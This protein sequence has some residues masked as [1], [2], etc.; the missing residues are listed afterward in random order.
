MRWNPL[1]HLRRKDD[2]ASPIEVET[3]GLAALRDQGLV[4]PSNQDQALATETPDGWL[5][6]AVADGVGGAAGGEV[7]SSAAMD[8]LKGATGQGSVSDPRLWLTSAFAAANGRVREMAAIDADRPHMA[9]TLVAALVDEEGRAW[10]ANVGDSRAYGLF[11][12]ALR[13]LTEDDSWV[14]ERVRSGELGEAEAEASPYRNMITRAIGGDDSVETGEIIEI[15]LEPG[16][17]LLLCSDGLYRMVNDSEIAEVLRQ[18]EP[19]HEIARRLVAMA[20]AAGGVDNIAVAI[21]RR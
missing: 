7:A 19:V 11:N 3:G 16:D 9:T 12:G 13:Q 4:R 1:R 14:A 20:N 5:L 17:V 2:A 15:Q 10:V 8:T 21:Y 18:A 6:L